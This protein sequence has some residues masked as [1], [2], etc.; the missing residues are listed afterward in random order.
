MCF[1]TCLV[2]LVAVVA[3]RPQREFGL[4]ETKFAVA[5]LAP[6]SKKDIVA[7]GDSRVLH[8]VAPDCFTNESN[9]SLR[10]H[11]FGFQGAPLSVEIL[12]VAV[13][14]LDPK[15]KRVLICGVT[16]NVF[17]PDAIAK[18]GFNEYRE[19]VKKKSVFR[20][21]PQ[22]LDY[23]AR[24]LEPIAMRDLARFARG[25]FKSGV[26]KQFHSNGWAETWV[27]GKNNPMSAMPLYERRFVNNMPD[28]QNINAFIDFVKNAT[29]DG[30]IV[31]GFQPPVPD[32]M[33][34]LENEASG[35][36]YETF[37]ARFESAGGIWISPEDSNISTYDGSHLDRDSAR[38][39]SKRM[40]QTLRESMSS[41]ELT[42]AFSETSHAHHLGK[43][44]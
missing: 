38:E 14:L 39:F 33:K 10:V 22:P 20:I 31:T 8:S 30:I 27:E 37:I 15:G 43:T 32:E 24:K 17:T 12:D 13:S 6:D 26:Y 36:S 18:N 11:N 1:L 25:D 34:Q 7:V 5:K 19:T 28:E 21:S 44:D 4:I 42:S 16:P 35:F 2:G 29:G 9:N 41:T 40:A 3:L 23:L